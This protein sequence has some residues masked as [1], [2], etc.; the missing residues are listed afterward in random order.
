MTFGRG[1]LDAAAAKPVSVELVR[2]GPGLALPGNA[3]CAAESGAVEEPGM[4]AADLVAGERVD[5]DWQQVGCPT[6]SDHWPAGVLGT[7]LVGH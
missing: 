4:V 3:A 2:I 5:R 1:T 7:P 6:E